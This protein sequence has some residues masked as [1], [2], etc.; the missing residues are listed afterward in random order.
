[1]LKSNILFA[2][3]AALNWAW[4]GMRCRISA[5]RT[6]QAWRARAEPTE[7]VALSETEGRSR[8]NSRSETRRADEASE[9]GSRFDSRQIWRAWQAKAEPEPAR[10][11]FVIALS[12]TN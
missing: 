10:Q 1:M 9:S 11:L 2:V 3:A 6:R 12:A 7:M 5:S 4:V 8:Q